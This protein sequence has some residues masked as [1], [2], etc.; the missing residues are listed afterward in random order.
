[1]TSQMTALDATFLELEDAD[2][3]AHMHIGG[4]L[5]FGPTPSGGAPSLEE[6]WCM[7]DA[8]VEALPRYRMRLDPPHPGRLARPAWR[9]DPTFDVRRHVHRATLP[10][11]GGWEELLEW[12]GV[13]FAQRLDRTAPLWEVVLVEGLGADHWALVT[14]THHALVDGVGSVDVAHLL[15]DA[16][17]EPRSD[18]DVHLTAPDDERRRPSLPSWIPARVL[19]RGAEAGLDLALHPTAIT[20]LA[21]R[22]LALAGLLVEDELH[23]AAHSSINQPIGGQRRLRAAGV[24]LD[25]LKL[26]K[27][28][29]GGTVNDVVLAAVTG[30]LRALLLQRGEQ[31]P[32]QG[33]RAMVPM[34][35]RAAGEHA[36]L[37]NTISSLFVELPVAEEHPIARYER[38]CETTRRLKASSKPLGADSLLRVAELAP[39]V[40]HAG[41]SR[42]LFATRL[43]NVTVTNVPGPTEPLY[44]FGAP[45]KTVWPLVP[46]AADHALGIAVLSYAGRVT[47]GINA[48]YDAA[49]DVDVLAQGIVDALGELQRVCHRVAAAS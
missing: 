13:Y 20:D 30:G 28:T 10:A 4:I 32:S 40:L 38:I 19:L 42:A 24:P 33:L 7:L 23:A 9:Q 41:L 25:E 47:F 34:N 36:E 48:D 46:L 16:S 45:L 31:P 26:I 22:S 2:P 5:V 11:P 3:S 29:L 17:P 35:V 8:R 49:P 18:D 6:L 15:L 12:A 27:D 44:A 43:F 1:M 39:P 37:G 14:K 21:R